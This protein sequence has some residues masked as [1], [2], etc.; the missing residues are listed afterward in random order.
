MSERKSKKGGEGRMMNS[1][2]AVK[3]ETLDRIRDV[4]NGMRVTHDEVINMALDQLI[5]KGEDPLVFG[6]KML[7]TVRAAK[8]DKSA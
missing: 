6:R 7:E 1:R 4:A 5:P 2:V 3:E 8:Q